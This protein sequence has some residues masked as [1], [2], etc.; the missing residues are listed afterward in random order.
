LFR[1]EL[2]YMLVIFLTYVKAR[3]GGK[4]SI[5]V[6]GNSRTANLWNLESSTYNLYK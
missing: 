3:V 6:G 4:I 1:V 2:T 5:V